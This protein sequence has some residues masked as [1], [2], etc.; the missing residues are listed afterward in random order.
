MSHS[1]L[2]KF[3]RMADQIGDYFAPQPPPEGA[4]GVAGHIRKFWTPK[5]IAETLAAIES[6]Q[7]SLNETAAHGF[8]ILRNELA[9]SGR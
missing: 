9:T 4:A 8:V 3:A 1:K 5:M 2:E 6:G 7:V